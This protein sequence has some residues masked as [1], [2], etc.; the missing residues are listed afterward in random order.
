M[1]LVLFVFNRSKW[2]AFDV[3][4]AH[5]NICKQNECSNN[6]CLHAR[7]RRSRFLNYIDVVCERNV[8]LLIS[9][10]KSYL[11]VSFSISLTLIKCNINHSNFFIL[12]LYGLYVVCS[13]FGVFFSIG[14]FKTVHICALIFVNLDSEALCKHNPVTIKTIPSD[15]M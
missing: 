2:R 6:H 3:W 14:R 12:G 13:V 9:I 4:R 8:I 5:G 10:S 1:D 7:I 15:P 11:F